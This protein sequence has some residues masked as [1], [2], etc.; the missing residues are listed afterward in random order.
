MSTPQFLDI[1]GAPQKYDPT[2]LLGIL[3]QL[4]IEINSMCKFIGV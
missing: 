2:Q 4:S 1:I 3:L